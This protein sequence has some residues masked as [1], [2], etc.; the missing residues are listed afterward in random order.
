MIRI[1]LFLPIVGIAGLVS[2]EEVPIALR[3]EFE[4]RY[5]A[6]QQ[7]V[8][9]KLDDDG[10]G[11]RSALPGSL[12]YDNQ[13]FRDVVSMG[14]HA[15]PF[16]MEKLRRS[17]A[18]S[19]ALSR[20]TKW[21]YHIMKTGETYGNQAWY[22]L[23]F[24][25]LTRAEGP[26]G[27]WEIWLRWW[28]ENP[29]WTAD[30]FSKIYAEWQLLSDERKEKEAEVQYQ[31]IKDLGIAALPYMMERVKQGHKGL[32]PAISYLTDSAVAV[33]A[34]PAVALEWWEKNKESWTIPFGPLPPEPPQAGESTEH[35]G[36]APAKAGTPEGQAAPAPEEGPVPPEV[37]ELRRMEAAAI[38]AA[39]EAR[40]KAEQARSQPAPR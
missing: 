11:F 28:G 31:A 1:F 10:L 7:Y 9:K 5:T 4:A 26:P 36:P 18:A 32:M 6:W 23:E 17:G 22:V 35:R 37:Q 3:Q 21:K 24:P 33:G 39:E 40:R 15:A 16:M 13:P 25:D 12:I 20:S 30:R 8:Q 34:E 2:K 19:E 38:K 29:K 27:V 14:P